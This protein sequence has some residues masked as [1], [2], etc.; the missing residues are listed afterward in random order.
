MEIG[1]NIYILDHP[2][3]TENNINFLSYIKKNQSIIKDM[4]VRINIISLTPDQLN[5]PE[6]ENFLK[7]KKIE[8]F[9]VLI[10]DNKIYKGLHEILHIYETNIVEYNKHIRETEI[11]KQQMQQ[12][13]LIKQQQMQQM[14]QQQQHQ[15]QQMQQQKQKEIMMQKE[16]QKRSAPID[17][18][19]QMHS[20]ISQQLQI[21]QQNDDDEE[22]PFGDGSNN[23]MMDSYRHMITR[24]NT[25]KKNPFSS[26]MRT[27]EDGERTNSQTNEESGPEQMQDIIYKQLQNSKNPMI[28]SKEGPREISVSNN[29]HQQ[30]SQNPRHRQMQM[31]KSQMNGDDGDIDERDDNIKGD[32]EEDI[33]NI[34]PSNIEHDGD[35]DPQDAILEKAYW[36]RMSETR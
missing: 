1:H 24:R 2:M 29:Q 28:P 10:T 6:I 5:E 18:D 36:N 3:F 30:M 20:Y 22:V 34:D 33:I 8:V 11:K 9:P 15:M 19:E 26:K 31:I 12:Q 7:S 23:I 14:Q 35:E 27:L 21:K 17:S 25:D 16:R 4:G 13:E 32:V